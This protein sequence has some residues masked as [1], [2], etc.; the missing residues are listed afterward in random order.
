MNYG[1]SINYI[2]EY[3]TQIS[4]DCYKHSIIHRNFKLQ[5]YPLIVNYK[6]IEKFLQITDSE[7]LT[8]TGTRYFWPTNLL[9][10]F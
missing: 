2:V 10:D 6:I 9:V 5:K 8:W 4:K 3:A 7:T 1:Y